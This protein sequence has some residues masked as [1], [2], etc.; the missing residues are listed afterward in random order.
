[1]NLVENWLRVRH[2]SSSEFV[3]YVGV[4]DFHDGE[5][6]RI[7]TTLEHTSVW[8]RGYSGSEYEIQ[9]D[10]VQTLETFEPEGMDPYALV[11]MRA[12]SPLRRFEF[13][14][15]SEDNH[16][17]LSIVATGFR[18]HTLTEMTE[19]SQ[20]V[21]EYCKRSGFSDQV[22]RGGLDYLLG[23]W[24][25]TVDEIVEGYRGLFDEFLNDMDGRRIISE[26]MPIATEV[27]RSR[28]ID[29][30]SRLDNSFLDATLE[31]EACIWGDDQAAK[32]R[33]NR[34]RDWWY[35]RRPKVLDFVE[36][37]DAWPSDNK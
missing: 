12:E 2:M 29:Q 18:V 8:V 27:E 13:A 9:F 16:K 20:A 19:P 22:C 28:T 30:L 25:R 23:S 10:G 34:E 32:R 1:M 7:S 6:L 4:P 36:D 15:N 35:Y 21:R 17:S 3:A 37:R 14:N 24:R 5:I 33:Y 31:Y 11:E 26:L